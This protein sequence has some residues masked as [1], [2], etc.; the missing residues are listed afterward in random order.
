[1]SGTS[2]PRRR[3]FTLVELLVVIAIVAVLVGLL[4]PAVQAVRE[5]AARAQCQSNLRQLGVAVHNFHGAN[6]TMPVYFGTQPAGD[7]PA[8]PWYPANRL[9]VYGGWFAHLLP[10]LE[11][12]NVY[13]KALADIRASGFNEPH[14]DVP[15]SAGSAG[16]IVVEHYNGHDWVYQGSTGGG[17]G[18]GYHEDGIWIDGVH[19][20][21]YKVLQCDADP[22]AEGKGLVYGWWG[23]TNYLANYNAWAGDPAY[24]AWAP[25]NRLSAIT[26]GT[27]NTVLFGE[28]YQNC[29]R[30]SRIALYSWWYHNFGLNWYQQANTQSFQD[31]PPVKDCDNWRAQS[32]HRG[33]MNV[34]LCDGSVR[35]VHPSVSQATWTSALLPT[36]GAALSGDW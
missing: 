26:D 24:G 27:S 25:P 13:N 32:G 7:E 9:K 1:M 6:R 12:D 29:D 14:W 23:A 22:S 16:G 8:Y 19:Q 17:G 18:S 34:A 36:D 11:Q 5:A 4:L 3:G 33:G 30:I 31:W 21:T 15:P 35:V 10:Y 20:A 28:G 2:P